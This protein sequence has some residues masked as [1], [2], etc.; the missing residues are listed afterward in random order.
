MTNSVDS[1]T[2]NYTISI[3]RVMALIH[4]LSLVCVRF[5]DIGNIFCLNLWTKISHPPHSFQSGGPT[6]FMVDPC[7][8]LHRGL[9]QFLPRR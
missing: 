2:Q 4:V 6:V 1:T 7:S 9:G 8:L 3:P 5:P